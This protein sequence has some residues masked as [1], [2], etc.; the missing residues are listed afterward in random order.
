MKDKKALFI[1]F[2]LSGYYDNIAKGLSEHFSDVEFHNVANIKFKYKNLFQRLHSVLYKVLKKQKLK[3][4][5]KLQPI[6]ESTQGKTYDYIIIV[7][8]DLFFD[9]QLI[10][11]KSRTKHFIAYYH[12]SINNI[13]RKKDVV[14]FF[15][16]VYTYEKKDVY[17]Y[18]LNFLTNFIYLDDY[19]NS[20]PIEYD[21]FTIM[22]KDY[23]L[24]TLEQVS[25]FFKKHNKKFNFLV[26][27]DK[28]QPKS[29]LFTFITERQ[30]NKQVLEHIS[31]CKLI[32]DI[33]KYG[34]Q[35]GLT[36]RVSESL[37]F[38]KKLITSNQDIKTY[39]FYNPKNI[40]VIEPNTPVNIPEDFF[41]TPYEALPVSLIQ[42][43]HYTN[44]ISTIIDDHKV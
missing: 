32:V 14:H 9:S 24:E 43:Y 18:K 21:A 5:Y 13:L 26:H 25:L 20:N 16:K 33:H 7:R 23:R 42:K 30:N 17:N 36:F 34:I 2:D 4:Y 35:D 8:P 10:K 31:K 22:S 6:V 28:E 44:W 40:Y 29:E 39:D 15:D 19:F 3:N 27:S 12:D 11:L 38:N 41:T 1:T 37:F